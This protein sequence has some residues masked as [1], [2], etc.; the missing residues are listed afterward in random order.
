MVTVFCPLKM[1]GEGDTVVQ[2]AEE[3]SLVVDCNVKTVEPVGHV[4]TTFPADRV[5]VSVGL[6]TGTREMLNTVPE[7]QLPPSKA[8]PYIVFDRIK[9][10]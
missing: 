2:K 9:P 4:K 1:T 6:L 10:A 3:P 7:S 5:I 8:V